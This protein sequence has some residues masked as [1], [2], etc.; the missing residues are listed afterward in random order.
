MSVVVIFGVLAGLAHVAFFFV[1]SVFWS[2]PAVWKVFGGK[3]QEH[4][5]LLA[6]G[7]KNQGWYNLF[8]AVGA[9]YGA[10]R[11]SRGDGSVLLTYTMLFMVGAGLVLVVTRPKMWRGFLIQATAPAIAA[12]ALLF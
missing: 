7:M 12:I 9:F 10:L 5:D 2:N 1:E 4:A 6:F 3:D 11:H 8:L